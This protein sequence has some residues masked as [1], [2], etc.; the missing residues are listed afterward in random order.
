MHHTLGYQDFYAKDSYVVDNLIFLNIIQ[1]FSGTEILAYTVTIAIASILIYMLIIS[2]K[3]KKSIRKKIRLKD[4]P[5]G[6]FIGVSNIVVIFTM[7]LIS[8][9][10]I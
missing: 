8:N 7:A 2:L 3:Q 1:I 9:F 4:M 5:I 6:Y 10:G